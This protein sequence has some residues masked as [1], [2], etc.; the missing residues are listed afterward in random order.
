MDDLGGTPELGMK[1]KE[2]L[3]TRSSKISFYIFGE[4]ISNE[5]DLDFVNNLWKVSDFAEGTLFKS[6]FSYKDSPITLKMI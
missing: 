6:P 5:N 3:Q 2:Y 1:T 4:E